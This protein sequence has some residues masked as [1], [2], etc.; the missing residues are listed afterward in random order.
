MTIELAG[1]HIEVDKKKIKNIHL[2][3]YPPDGRVRIACPEGVNDETIRLYLV[4]KLS[5]IKRQQKMLLG[6]HRESPRQFLNRESHYFL[7]KKY[8]LKVVEAKGPPQV[9]LVNKNFITIHIS[10]G[11]SISQK[12]KALKEWYREELK[13]RIPQYITKWEKKIGVQ[14][15]DWGVKT[16]RTKWGT[17]NINKKR[18]WLN[19][20]LAKK[21]VE[22]L[23]Y[24]IVHEL[25][26]L[27]ERNHNDK[28]VAHMNHFLPKWKHYREEL[29]SLPVSH[30]EWGY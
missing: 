26:H 3:V 16:M 12:E 1:L 14:L 4:S 19:L 22:C 10:P 23:E 13:K 9:T 18:I 2:A 6:K 5:W 15:E 27:L 20:E 21:P 11:A 25:I 24:I 30:L 8:M 28:F 17:C 29:N 7:G